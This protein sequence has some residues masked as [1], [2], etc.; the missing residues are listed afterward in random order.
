M[1]KLGLLGEK[2]SHS[3]S[4]FIHNKI[5]EHNNIASYELFEV[6]RSDIFLIFRNSC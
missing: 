6:A 2:L 4:P 5:F 3:L 1:I